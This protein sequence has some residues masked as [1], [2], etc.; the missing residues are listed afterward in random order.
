MLVSTYVPSQSEIKET[1]TTLTA[2]EA[3]LHRCEAELLRLREL[4]NRLEQKRDNIRYRTEE[5]RCLISAFRKLPREILEL[6]FEE[7][8][9]ST[10]YTLS[11]STRRHSV[12]SLSL[13]LYRVSRRWRAIVADRPQLWSSISVDFYRVRRDINPLLRTFLR[14]SASHTLKLHLQ[15]S[16]R[17]D[18]HS[19]SS[20]MKYPGHFGE[21]AFVLLAGE[22]SRCRELSL[23]IE[24]DAIS[25][26]TPQN[27]TQVS[28]CTLETF[29]AN[30]VGFSILHGSNRWFWNGISTA[31]KLKDA[32]L[33]HPHLLA[34][35]PCSQLTSLTLGTVNEGAWQSILRRCHSLEMVNA[36]DVTREG[37][38]NDDSTPPILLPHLRSVSLATSDSAE[39][40]SSFFAAATTPSLV[41]V[42]LRAASIH[43][44]RANL[45]A[46]LSSFIAMLKRSACSD[47]F[48]ELT[49]QCLRGCITP[50]DINLIMQLSPNLTSLEMWTQ[51]DDHPMELMENIVPQ[52][53]PNLTVPQISDSNEPVLAPKLTHLVINDVFNTAFKTDDIA[54]LILDMAESRSAMR[55]AQMGRTGVSPLE[56][57]SLSF[58]DQPFWVT[59]AEVGIKGPLIQSRLEA[60]QEAGVE[61][62]I[63]WYSDANDD[64]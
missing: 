18:F 57:L 54:E 19:W 16:S 25:L 29:H 1:M 49:L 36:K 43:R 40:F 23:S 30:T 50:S 46:D 12:K 20:P 58:A 52:L 47:T 17:E 8:C 35:I 31:S 14:H 42:K 38:L 60:L 9:L 4:V 39:V 5:R 7:A 32:S 34:S 62:V 55:L 26:L 2:A 64:V 51:G 44:W 59:N 53:L 41:S 33:A 48:R 24:E 15:D 3:E 13:S 28:F 10:D 61:C 6:I 27:L 11:I 45:D 56:K 63:E 22:F 37:H 21:A